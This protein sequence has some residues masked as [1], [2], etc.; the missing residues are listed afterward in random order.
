MVMGRFGQLSGS[1]LVSGHGEIWSGSG[2]VSGHGEIW[3]VVR[4]RVRVS[5]WS[6][7]ETWPFVRVKKRVGQLSRSGRGLVIGQSGGDLAICQGQ[8]EGWSVVRVRGRVDH[9]SVRERLGHVR[10]MVGQG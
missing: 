7:R 2:L 6:A 3:S 5:H 10:V 8:G 9:W 1:G 4:I